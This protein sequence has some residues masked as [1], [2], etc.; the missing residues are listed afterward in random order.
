VTRH[1]RARHLRSLYL[2]RVRACGSV[3]FTCCAQMSCNREFE[4]NV[5]KISVFLWKTAYYPPLKIMV[6]PANVYLHFFLASFVISLLSL[7]YIY[8]YIRDLCSHCIRCFNWWIHTVIGGTGILTIRQDCLRNMCSVPA[9][10]TN[11]REEES[12]VFEAT[13]T[14]R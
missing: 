8:I 9:I 12:R 4:K 13:I 10:D 2:V 3:A 14:F 1:F 5:I 6:R 7:A 11:Q